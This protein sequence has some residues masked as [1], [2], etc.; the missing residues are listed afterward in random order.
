VTN[1]LRARTSAELRS[2]DGAVT[3]SIGAALLMAGEDEYAW[4]ARGDAALYQAKATGRDRVVIDEL[5]ELQAPA[6][7]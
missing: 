3:T 2:P 1:N 5:E 7:S 4:L 6:K